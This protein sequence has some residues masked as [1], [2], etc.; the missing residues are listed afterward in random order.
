MKTISGPRLIA[1]VLLGLILVFF[2]VIGTFGLTLF[3]LEKI[4]KPDRAV[5]QAVKDRMKY[6]GIYYA[7]C[8]GDKCYFYC[9]GKKVRL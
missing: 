3:I 9:K 2:L 7:E 6:H 8:D 4:N 5:S 1:A